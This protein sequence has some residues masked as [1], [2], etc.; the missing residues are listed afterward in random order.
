M[1]TDGKLGG[2]FRGVF[3][4]CFRVFPGVSEG[5][6]IPKTVV[7]RVFPPGGLSP[8][9][10]LISVIRYFIIFIGFIKTPLLGALALIVVS[11]MVRLYISILARK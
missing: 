9:I 7:L 8:I 11:V 3:P 10:L 5:S 2:C 1:K 6:M 4:G